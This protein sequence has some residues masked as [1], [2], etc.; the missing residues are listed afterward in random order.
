[1]NSR[2]HRAFSTVFFAPLRLCVTFLV[3]SSVVMADD[4]KPEP[5]T[6][7]ITYRVIGLFSKDREKAL[8]SGFDDL[9]PDFKLTSVNFDEAEI[10]VEFS[11][12]KLWPGQKPERV[13]EL[14]NDKVRQATSHT[15]GVKSRRDIARDKLKTVTI[16]ARGCNCAAC[17]LAAYEIV[18]AVDGVYQATASFKE[19][20]ITALIDPT[21]ADQAKLEE[22]LRKRGVDVGP[23]AKK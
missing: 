9:A 16:Q 19:E 13:A 22:A 8:R 7:H 12:A 17:N 23:P 5:K 11:P 18:A 6:E 21:K 14:V 15:L 1:M 4:K 20:R 3:L 2:T 10:T